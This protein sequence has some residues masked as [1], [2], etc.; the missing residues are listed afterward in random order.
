MLGELCTVCSM[1]S[2]HFSVVCCFLYY[3]VRFFKHIVLALCKYKAIESITRISVNVNRDN[4]LITLY[5]KCN[6]ISMLD[7]DV[8]GINF[9]RLPVAI[10]IILL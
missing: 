1:Y 7:S 5:T 10:I 2:T 8:T 6:L 3:C 9:T 4:N